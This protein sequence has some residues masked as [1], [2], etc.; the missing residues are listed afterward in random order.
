[1]GSSS[2]SPDA[3]E[4]TISGAGTAVLKASNAAPSLSLE[5]AQK[6]GAAPLRVSNVADPVLDL[7]AVN[8][9]TLLAHG[10]GSGEGCVDAVVDGVGSLPGLTYATLADA[11]AADKRNICVTA[12]TSETQLPVWPASVDARFVAIHFAP[13][14]QID[15]SGVDGAGASATAFTN[16]YELQLLGTSQT[17]FFNGMAPQT[18]F[19]HFILP[20]NYASLGLLG[21]NIGTSFSAA[22]VNFGESGALGTLGEVGVTAATAI[23]TSC[24]VDVSAP[25]AFDVRASQGTLFFKLQIDGGS[26]WRLPAGGTPMLVF[27][28]GLQTSSCHFSDLHCSVPVVFEDGAK[29]TMRGCYF[30]KSFTVK[31]PGVFEMNVNSSVFADAVSLGDVMGGATY[32]D[33]ENTT[34]DAC[35]FQGLVVQGTLT[36][37]VF[38]ACTFQGNVTLRAGAVSALAFSK[39]GFQQALRLE[40]ASSY[41][42]SQ[43]LFE[44]SIETCVMA[45]LTLQDFVSVRNSSVKASAII[46]DLSVTQTGFSGIDF[47]SFSVVDTRVGGNLAITS[48]SLVAF[49]DVSI[50]G[51]TVANNLNVQGT[52]LR[53]QFRDPPSLRVSSSSVGVTFSLTAADLFS[54]Y[55]LQ[56]NGNS[57]G[58]QNAAAPAL[59]FRATETFNVVASTVDNNVF[60]GPLNFVD[61]NFPPVSATIQAVS[62]SNNTGFPGSAGAQLNIGGENTNLSLQFVTINQNSFTSSDA[63][64]TGDLVRAYSCHFCQNSWFSLSILGGSGS[65]SISLSD[66]SNNMFGDFFVIQSST[67]SGTGI[68]ES[69]ISDNVC[70]QISVSAGGFSKNVVSGNDVS[71]LSGAGNP[72]NI[73]IAVSTSGLMSSNV[74]SGNRCSDMNFRGVGAGTLMIS[75]AVVTGTRCFSVG[76]L[77]VGPNAASDNTSLVT[78]NK[79]PLFT[80]WVDFAGA[81]NTYPNDLLD[82]GVAPVVAGVGLNRT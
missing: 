63:T 16:V 41:G 5:V 7:D 39:S 35:A 75:D 54:F 28:K 61:D 77:T 67:L 57:L 82:S 62:I 64:I 24:I 76:G 13:G 74:F 32:V 9:R 27:K 23:M 2:L 58:F 30:D 73:L 8:L 38:T 21:G 11:A 48:D 71:A 20:K 10:G 6:T 50:L 37:V 33:V 70:A 26:E 78:N 56:I 59:Q 15:W 72:G 22:F 1:M 25:W 49:Q 3:L 68:T 12:K 31:T 42:L 52:T 34:F 60:Y 44:V 47:V 51:S 17:E 14:G 40:Y 55:G 29:G 79:A 81:G 69:T 66:I 19:L 65:V 80:G 4:F 53:G 36:S 46:G 18:L 43:T 45:S